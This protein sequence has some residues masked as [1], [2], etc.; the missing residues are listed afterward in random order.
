M[1]YRMT[2]VSDRVRVGIRSDGCINIEVWPTKCHNPDE[3]PDE[4]LIPQDAAD[5]FAR[6]LIK[7][8]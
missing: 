3:D 8:A 2:E 5:E 6:Y 7:N 4:I 1:A